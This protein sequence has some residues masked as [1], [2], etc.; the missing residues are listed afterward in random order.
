[1][2]WVAASML[3][4]ALVAARPVRARADE[5]PPAGH[6]VLAGAAMAVP[7]YALGVTIHEGTHA[8]VAK[9][10]GYP[11]VRVQLYPGVHHGHF[12]FGYVEYRGRMPVG[13]RTFFLLAPKFVD[14][15]MMGGYAALVATDSL[16]SNH[17]GQLAL[18]VLATGFWVDFSKDLLAPWRPHDV[19]MALDRNGIH[20]FWGKLPYWLLHAGLAA[21]GSIAIVRGYQRLFGIAQAQPAVVLPVVQL[22]W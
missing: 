7:T 18:A 11:L 3:C 8:L 6:L 1:M 16:P 10:Y 21:A 19:N 4:V 22:A 12:Y 2:R 5:R 13:K 15:A 20:G 14:M 17:Y 9:A